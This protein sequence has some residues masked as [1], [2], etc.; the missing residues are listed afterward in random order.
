MRQLTKRTISIFLLILSV[1]VYF[2]CN[3]NVCKA[4]VN[5]K[6]ASEAL[7]FV[8][9]EILVKFKKG[10]SNE[11]INEIN[12]LHGATIKGRKLI[13]GFKR[14]KFSNN[15][16]SA[17]KL[18]EEYRT[19]EEVVFAE[20]NYIVKATAIPN[21]GHFNNLWGL[22]NIGQA[23]GTSGADIGAIDA[24]D[25]QTDSSSIICAVIDTGVDYNHEDLSQNIWI[26]LD[27]IA[28]NGIDDDKNGF[29]DDVYGW[30]FVNNDNDPFDDNSHGTHV[31]GTISAEGNNS[32]GVS[33]VSWSGKIM[34]LKFLDSNGIGNTAGAINAINYAIKMGARVLNN[35]WGG[36]GF[37]QALSAAISKANKAKALFIVAA[38]NNET[39]NDAA[40]DYPSSYNIRNII[41]VAATDNNDN[42][43]NFSNYGAISVHVSAPGVSIYSTNPGNGYGYKSGTSMAAP[44]VSGAAAI[45]MEI[46]SDE[47]PFEI[48]SR[49]LNS[50]DL[51][52]TLEGKVATGGRVNLYNA[53]LGT[54]TPP[55]PKLSIIYKDNM[56]EGTNG[57]VV[58]GPTALWNQSSH[59][60]DSSF[61][62]WYYG[63]DLFFNYDTSTATSGSLISPDIDLTNVTGSTLVFS[64]FLETEESSLYDKAIVRISAD[65]GVTYSDIFTGLTTNGSFAQETINI[66]AYDDNIINLQFFFDS[67]DSF[68]NNFEGWYVDD[69]KIKGIPNQE[70]PLANAGRDQEVKDVDGNGF[71]QVTLNGSESSDPNGS[72]SLYEWKE[73]DLLL[74]TGSL[75]IVDFSVGTH[76]VSLTV[77]DSD[78]LSNRNDVLITVNGSVSPV[79]IA[80]QDQTVDNT[81]IVPVNVN[82]NTQ[83]VSNTNVDQTANDTDG[84]EIE[85]IALNVAESFVPEDTMIS[86]E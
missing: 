25:I 78:G 39:N 48:K 57:W 35:S 45:I 79:T 37:S 43:A 84:K 16:K 41:S 34:A 74:G 60:T 40:P 12:K 10:I 86:Y 55:G 81:K 23:E 4:L 47:T 51:I 46:F 28:D 8:K 21:D 5:D 32:I 67:V 20:P 76:T 30:D 83:L 85:S 70:P 77:T 11:T 65:G 80:G 31:A 42:L 26:N 73:D 72:I 19:L 38:G 44:Y 49:I 64:H 2:F 29:V 14:L 68:L 75:V 6:P 9:D 3:L 61:T 33:G 50:V 27:K 36:S 59:R 53:I 66:S 52:Q 54:T 15:T 82:P 71:E 1:T 22:N 56:E 17:R 58:S 13:G 18:I 69:V 63:N 24:W 7:A 62:S